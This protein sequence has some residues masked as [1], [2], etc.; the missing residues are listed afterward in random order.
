MRSVVAII[1][2]L[3]PFITPGPAAAAECPGNPNALG[4]SRT[5]VV[6][7]TEHT[8]VGSFQYRE[9]LPLNDKEVV[10]TFDD[11]PLPPYTTRILD[12]LAKECVKATFFMVG[13][14]VRS[15]PKVVRRVHAE[16]HTIGDHSMTHPFTFNRMSVDQAARE[17]EGG[18]AALRTALKDSPGAVA[19]FFR[20]PALLRQDAVEK[21]LASRNVM[22]WSVDFM[23]DDW[24]HISDREIVR[25]ALMRLKAKG[26]GILLLHDIHP[27]T[28]LALPILLHE[29]KVRGYRI[30]QVVPAV[31]GLVKTATLPEQWVVRHTR[32][33]REKDQYPWPTAV[34]AI[35]PAPK[36]VL[37]A[38][39]VSSFGSA[40]ARGALMLVSL[41]AGRERLHTQKGAVPLP[42]RAL[43]P[44]RVSF[45]KAPDREVLP[46]PAVENFRYFRL[47]KNRKATRKARRHNFKKH[48][49]SG[50][51][52]LNPPHQRNHTKF[53]HPKPKRQNVSR[54]HLQH[55][56][57]HE[58]DLP[59]PT[60]SLWGMLTKALTY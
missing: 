1:C 30:V 29:L 9:S 54:P 11:G 43:W 3:A 59:K 7:P 15:F 41:I 47:W 22:T 60:A 56:T 13:T 23:A 12:V 16:G 50:R 19:P 8:R 25:R 2:V 21:Y 57:G 36:P 38:P 5:I 35:G 32:H 52:E 51:K 53:K 48:I 31:N 49:V 20:F 27:A 40:D 44:R 26:K 4:T 45:A 17:I 42:V 18:F 24:T 33:R 34:A 37:A 10:L 58:I 14:M 46:A 55:R 28:A 39:S 6:D